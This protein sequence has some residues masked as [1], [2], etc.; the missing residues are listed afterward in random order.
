MVKELIGKTKKRES[1]LEESIIKIS[2][3]DR[4]FFG[5]LVSVIIITAVMF[6]LVAKQDEANAQLVA[7]GQQTEAKIIGKTYGKQVGVEYIFFNSILKT[8]DTSSRAIGQIY[9]IQI[10]ERFLVYY[11]EDNSFLD[12][13]NGSLVVIDPSTGEISIDVDYY[14]IQEIDKFVSLDSILPPI[15]EH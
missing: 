2:D 7:S 10:D 9:G 3:M 14:G 8:C 15:C 6:Y 1:L 5:F 12:L 11:N 4:D 13:E